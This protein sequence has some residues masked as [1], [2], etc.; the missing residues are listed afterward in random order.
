MHSVRVQRVDITEEAVAR[1]IGAALG[2][3]V[4]ASTDGPA[5]VSVRQG[6]FA[7]ARVTWR[8]DGGVDTVFEVHGQGPPVPLGYVTLRVVNDR[9]LGRRVADAI[10]ASAELGHGG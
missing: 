2:E 6:F 10:K 5:T 1:V 3:G 4:A 8:A 7:R 9:G